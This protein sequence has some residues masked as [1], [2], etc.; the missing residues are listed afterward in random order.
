VSWLIRAIVYA[1]VGVDVLVTASLGPVARPVTLGVY[2]ACGVLFAVWAVSD[3]RR[4]VTGAPAGPLLTGVLAL[5]TVLSASL[6]PV[7]DGGAMIALAVMAV[8]EAGTEVRISSGWAVFGAGVAAAAGGAV[9]VDAAVERTLGVVGG[10]AVGLLIGF[11]RRAYRV[12]AEQSAALLARTEQLRAER[13]RGAVLDERARL[14]REIHDVLAHSLGALGIQIQAARALLEAGTAAPAGPSVDV[15]RVDAV[16]ATAQRMASD[17]LNETRRAVHAL[18]SDR[19]SL[20]EELT[21]TAV[22][23]EERHGTQVTVHVTGEPGPLPP[24]QTLALLRTAQESLVNAAKHAPG[25]PVSVALAYGREDV[26]MTVVNPLDAPAA[27]APGPGGGAGPGGAPGGRTPAAPA[28]S[29]VDGGYGLTG[30]RERLLL[31]GGTLTAGRVAAGTD[32]DA[33]ASGVSD[34]SDASGAD[35]AASGAST[36]GAVRTP[37]SADAVWAV[38]ARVPRA[39]EAFEALGVPDGA[40]AS[41]ALSAGTGRTARIGR[42]TR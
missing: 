23:H 13:H 11:N 3:R 39:P 33:A 18:R 26:A 1:V 29:T 36:A 30:M 32:A 25:R 40:D 4:V 10:L 16:L 15:A 24:D 41:D 28:M 21:A 14:A 8:V 22:A 19:R 35:D 17:G 37:G 31:L 38:T 12:R 6:A 5:T 2:A 42:S 34:V 20:G 9:V 27:P 7:G